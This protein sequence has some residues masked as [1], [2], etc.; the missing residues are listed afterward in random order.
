M[1]KIRNRSKTYNF[2]LGAGVT[3][4]L[5]AC[6]GVSIDIES[7]RPDLSGVWADEPLLFPSKT[8]GESICIFDCD[9]F[10]GTVTQQMH[11]KALERPT[12]RPELQHVVDDLHDRQVDVDSVLRCMPPGVPRIGPPD[13]IVQG[14]N[15]VVFLYEDPVG[16]QQ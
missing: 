5:P 2:I 10:E 15:Q 3:L 1:N 7:E 12:Y 14:Q 16:G 6:D 4:L 9:D 11:R 8:D 13:E